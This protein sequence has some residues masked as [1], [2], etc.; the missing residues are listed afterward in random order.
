[1][2]IVVSARC[3]TR[4]RDHDYSII[5]PLGAELDSVIIVVYVRWESHKNDLDGENSRCFGP[6]FDWSYSL[7]TQPHQNISKT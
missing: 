6:K 5:Y 2:T 1:V 7:M 4:G 3:R